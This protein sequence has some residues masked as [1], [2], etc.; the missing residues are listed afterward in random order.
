M[1]LAYAPEITSLQRFVELLTC[2]SEIDVDGKNFD[3]WML[4]CLGWPAGV[5][6]VLNIAIFPPKPNEAPTGRSSH[7]GAFAREK[8]APRGSLCALVKKSSSFKLFCPEALGR[9]RISGLE[10]LD[11]DLAV[12]GGRRRE[13]RGCE[14]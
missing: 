7:A 14:D 9:R 1:L 13:V 4:E 5:A 2:R 8:D 3:M 11:R 12:K 6:I 10:G